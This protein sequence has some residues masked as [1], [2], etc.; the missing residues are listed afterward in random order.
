MNSVQYFILLDKIDI[1]DEKSLFE[2]DAYFYQ[3][4]IKEYRAIEDNLSNE[5]DFFSRDLIDQS[6]YRENINL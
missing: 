1:R 2:I 4:R 6:I 3:T 5:I